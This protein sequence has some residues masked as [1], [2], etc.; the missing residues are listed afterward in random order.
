MDEEASGLLS[1]RFSKNSNA[2]RNRIV[3]DQIFLSKPH[4]T[5]L[6]RHYLAEHESL[7]HLTYSSSN[8]TFF[9]KY[10]LDRNLH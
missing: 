6:I 3:V 8:E 1:D 2:C 9:F 7:S 5:N 4:L 10:F